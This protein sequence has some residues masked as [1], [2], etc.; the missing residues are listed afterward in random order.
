MKVNAQ[1]FFNFCARHVPLLRAL[2]GRDGE[3]SQPEV[4]RIISAQVDPAEELPETSWRRLQEFQVLTPS[5]PGSQFFFVA[6]PVRRLLSYLFDESNPATPEM[7]RGYIASIEAL[8]QQLTRALDEEDVTGVSLAFREI[9]DSLRRIYTDL[10]ETHHC[11]LTEVARFKTNRQQVSVR[12]KYRRIV[13]WME[14]YVEPMIEIVRADGLMRASFDETE[15]LLRLA[16]D[17]SLFNDH[18]ALER[19]LRYLRLVR[20]HALRVFQPCTR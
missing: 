13:H 9:N 18:P 7:I 6:E 15:R 4:M 19:N 11:I 14:R 5:E 2:A 1:A 20:K 3:I 16:N 17:R 12:D 10:E 8:N